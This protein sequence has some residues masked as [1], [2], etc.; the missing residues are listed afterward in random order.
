MATVYGS[1]VKGYWRAFCTYTVASTATTYTVKAKTGVNCYKNGYKFNNWRS[2]LSASGY[3]ASTASST[4]KWVGGT[5]GNNYTTI[6]EKTYTYN[7]TTASQTKTINYNTENR[8]TGGTAPGTSSGSVTITI[9]ALA[10][11]S[12]EYNANGENVIGMPFKQTK[13]YNETITL[14]AN[15]PTRDDYIFKGYATTIN[16]QPTYY[17]GDLYNDNSALVLYAQWEADNYTITLDANGG[18]FNPPIEPYIVKAGE[19][20]SFDPEVIPTKQNFLFLGWAPTPNI[21]GYYQ[22]GDFYIPTYSQTWYAQWKEAYIPSTITSIKAVRADSNNN[23]VE[24]VSGE[25]AKIEWKVDA[26]RWINIDGS[27]DSLFQKYL[28][29]IEA[30]DGP[31]ENIGLRKNWSTTSNTLLVSYDNFPI[32]TSTQY[33]VKVAVEDYR[34]LEDL[35]SNT[36]KLGTRFKTTYISMARFTMDF[37]ADGTAICFFG[38]APD[39]KDGLFLKDDTLE[40]ELTAVLGD[41]GV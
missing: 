5:T 41:I 10:S 28:L 2:S 37:N 34:T 17:P 30:I 21:A 4:T 14:N 32:Y 12:I 9:P 24:D 27:S 25:S 38:E 33:A 20:F 18:Q 16:G 23:Y 1:L 6:S 11:Y 40:A 7:K 19:G 39:D 29:E 26:G 15:P 22:P 36:N 8:Y 35:E 31:L 13:Y 3:S